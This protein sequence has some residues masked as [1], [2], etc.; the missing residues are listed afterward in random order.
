MKDISY[1]LNAPSWELG[2][3]ATSKGLVA[4]ALSITMADGSVI[5][6]NRSGGV[7]IPQNVLGITKVTSKAKWILIVEKD[8]AFQKLLDSDGLTRLGPVIF[9][10]VRLPSQL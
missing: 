6:C 8:A 7:L 1:I 5:V 3:L 10:T 9:I 4:G 2:I